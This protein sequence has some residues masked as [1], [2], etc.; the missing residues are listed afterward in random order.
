[1][2]T[3]KTT[4]GQRHAE[5]T[6]PSQALRMLR[7]TVEIGRNASRKQIH[8][9][10]RELRNGVFPSATLASR[11]NKRNLINLSQRRNPIAHTLQRRIPQKRHPLIS[12]LLPNLAPRLLRQQHLANLIIELQQFMNRRAPAIP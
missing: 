7:G 5:L 3:M 6:I 2:Q 8:P 12:R 11:L 10:S 4:A 1:M 9:K